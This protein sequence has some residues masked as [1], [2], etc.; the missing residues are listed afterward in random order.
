MGEF[1]A[2]RSGLAVW[3][4]CGVIAKII[5]ALQSSESRLDGQIFSAAVVL[6]AYMFI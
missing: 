5:F 3:L 2:K 6:E 1:L 4:G